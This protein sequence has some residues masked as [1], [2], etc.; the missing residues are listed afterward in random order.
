MGEAIQ[1]TPNEGD[2]TRLR[3]NL[4]VWL[5]YNTEAFH[6]HMSHELKKC[7]NVHVTAFSLS[8]MSEEYLKSADVPELIFVE[9]NGNWAQKMVELQ[10]YDL[11]LEDENLSLVVLGDESDNGA[12][13][14]AL[15]LGASDFLSHNVM[16]SDLLPLLKKT[17]A[18]KLE[19]SNY[20]E[21]ILFL[22][23]KGGWGRQLWL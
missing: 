22:N 18:E 19:N 23:T 3:T 15:R 2:I 10:G 1:M 6:S 13:K 17:A 14:I 4:K 8:A 20:G 5:I 16:L 11:S 21:F 12:L 7:R 9:A